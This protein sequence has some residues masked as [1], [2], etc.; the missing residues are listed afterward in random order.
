MTSTVL[1]IIHPSSAISS[2]IPLRCS[3]PIVAPSAAL[4]P[5][6]IPVQA[7]V[8]IGIP[9]ASEQV[10]EHPPQVR[11]VGFGLELEAAA[12]REVLG[13]L[14]GTPLTERGD[15]DALLL[16]HDELVLFG[17]GL[18]LESLPR[19]ASLEKVNEDVSN[20]LEIVAAALL[21]PQVVVDGRVTGRAR[22]GPSLPLGDV[23]EG[24]GVAVP[25][26]Q[27]EVNAVH[28]VTGAAPVGD[29]VGRLDVAMD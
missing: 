1:P 13:E 7:G 26:G 2:Y 18:S 20:G 24:A 22:E 8:V 25:L 19:E 4:N 14:A 17:G 9:L 5:V 21:H 12:I 3:T 10:A 16:F 29:E 11:N 28:E 15:G 23:L 6:P 27:A